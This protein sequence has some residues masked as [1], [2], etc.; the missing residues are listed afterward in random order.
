MFRS[1]TH[2]RTNTL[3]LIVLTQLWVPLNLWHFVLH[4]LELRLRSTRHWNQETVECIELVMA[5]DFDGWAFLWVGWVDFWNGC[6][7]RFWR[8]WLIYL[9]AAHGVLRSIALGFG[10]LSFNIVLRWVCTD[11]ITAVA[12]GGRWQYILISAESLIYNFSSKTVPV[13]FFLVLIK[14]LCLS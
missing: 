3:W 7:R 1:R 2:Q 10:A 9:E 8:L 5:V 14:A 4:S 13:H 11:I 12:V 6:H